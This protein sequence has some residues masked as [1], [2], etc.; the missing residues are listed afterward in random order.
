LTEIATNILKNEEERKKIYDKIFDE[1]TLAVYKEN[2]K[3]TEKSISYD[4]FVKLA[5]EK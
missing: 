3:L 4:D 5:S 1:R 2:F